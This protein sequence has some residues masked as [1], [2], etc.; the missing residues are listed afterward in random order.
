MPSPR[1]DPGKQLKRLEQVHLPADGRQC[2]DLVDRDFHPRH[3]HLLLDAVL[4]L[5]RHDRLAQFQSCRQLHVELDVVG[6]QVDL[7]PLRGV[8]DV[9]D[10]DVVRAGGQGQGVKAIDVG[11]H[12][13]ARGLGPHCGPDE[14]FSRGHVC[15]VSAQGVVGL[16]PSAPNEEHPARQPQKMCLLHAVQKWTKADE[17]GPGGPLKLQSE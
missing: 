13:L 1:L 8:A 17:V 5:A 16:G 2:L 7:K 15:D 10:A 9:I 14:C 6:A 3:L 11:R 4:L 12:A